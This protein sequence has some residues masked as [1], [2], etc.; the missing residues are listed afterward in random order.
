LAQTVNT[1]N[2]QPTIGGK[3]TEVAA[4]SGRWA[5]LAYGAAACAE[6]GPWGSFIC[7]GLGAAFGE[8]AVRVVVNIFAGNPYSQRPNEPE[9]QWMNRL[10]CTQAVNPPSCRQ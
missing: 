3:L 4:A 2:S 10:S 6:F 1:V 5:G 7:G 8:G 9:Q